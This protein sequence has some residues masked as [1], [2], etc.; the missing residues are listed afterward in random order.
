MVSPEHDHSVRRIVEH[1]GG[2]TWRRDGLGVLLGPVDTGPARVSLSELKYTAHLAIRN[3]RRFECRR[4]DLQAELF[5][6]EPLNWTCLRAGSQS[7][8][9]AFVCRG[10]LF[11][12][13]RSCWNV[14]ARLLPGKRSARSFGQIKRLL[15]STMRSTR[16]WGSC[17]LRSAIRQ[18]TPASS[19]PYLDAATA[20]SLR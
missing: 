8:G 6:L 2:S 9:S 4:K 3:S 5:G 20:S 1:C 15:S 19:K 12:F 18:T 13:L 7:L 14:Q 11:K 10:S 17:A 16:E